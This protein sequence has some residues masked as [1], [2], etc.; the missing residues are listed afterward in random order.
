MSAGVPDS[1]AEL[2]EALATGQD[3][4]LNELMRRWNQPLIAFLLRYTGNEAD[5]TGRL[6]RSRG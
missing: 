1:D 6:R 3:A 4:A 5:A 2:M